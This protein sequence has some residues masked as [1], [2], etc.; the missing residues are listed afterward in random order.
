MK[1][2]ALKEIRY[3]GENH[4]VG[5]VFDVREKDFKLLRLIGKVDK[6]PRQAPKPAEKQAETPNRA[7]RKRGTYHRRDMKAE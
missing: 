4:K 3:A 6:A 5:E 2:I 7:S 1:A